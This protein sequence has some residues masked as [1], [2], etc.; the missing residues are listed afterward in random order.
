MWPIRSNI[1]SHLT[2]LIVSKEYKWRQTQKKA[3]KQTKAVITK[4][5]LL[6]YA[7]H[8]KK[9]Y[10]ETDA[11]NYQLGGRIFQKEYQQE[12]NKTVEHDIAFYTRKLNS[13]QKK[14]STIEK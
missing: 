11:S 5:T 1:L 3:F 6:E 7:D 2:E 13:A 9:L 8:N 12:D 4:D 14:Y 10:I